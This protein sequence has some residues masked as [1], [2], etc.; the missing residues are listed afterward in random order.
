MKPQWF[1]IKDIPYNQ[2]WIDDTYWWPHFL[3]DTKFKGYFK[4]DG[5]DTIVDYKITIDNYN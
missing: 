2:M 3:N 1:D 4:Y 5:Y